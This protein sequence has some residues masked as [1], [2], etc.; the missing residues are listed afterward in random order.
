M[1]FDSAVV[2]QLGFWS[3]VVGTLLSLGVLYRASGRDPLG[4]VRARLLL[5]VPWGTV[6][7]IAG[8]YVVFYVLQGAAQGR[9][10]VVGFRSWSYTYPLGMILAPFAHGSLGHLTGNV[11]STVVYAPVAEYA[12]SHYPTERGTHTFGSWEHNPFVRIGLFVAGSVVV[13]LATSLFIPGALVGFSGVVFAFAGFALVTR[14]LL[15]VFAL[16][17]RRVVN[18][19]YV[20][21]QDPVLTARAEPQF[22]TPFWANIAIQGHALG[23]LVGVLAGL[24]VGRRRDEWASPARVWFAVLVFAVAQ[25][26]YAF[27]WQ[28]STAEFVLF[29]GVGTALV[30]VLAAVVAA[31]VI[32]RDRVIVPRIDLSRREA[33]AGLLLAVVLAIS[34]AAIPFNLVTIAGAGADP[35]AVDDGIEIR[36]YTVTYAE[37]VPNQYVASVDI[38]VIGQP[39]SINESGVVVASSGRSAWEVVVPASRLAFAGRTTVPVGGPGWRETVVANRTTWNVVGGSS[40]YKVYLHRTGEQRRLAFAAE[41]ATVPAV[42]DDTRI[43]IAPT[44]P[45]YELEL[46]R[47]DS[48]VGT[49]PVPTEGQNVTVADIT[50]NRTGKSLRAIHD[51]TRL[52]IATFRLK[53]KPDREDE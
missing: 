6:A 33:A 31:A 19:F 34:V 23:L 20:S 44:R 40:T 30:F 15:A 11:I 24:W 50:F 52:R 47:N 46:R 3:L 28:V 35:G 9:P 25:A 27:Y 45:G 7:V 37:G 4:R 22:V 2:D 26:L 5:G 53:G 13:G 12:W 17:A 10:V 21:V 8:L 14:P 38:P 43:R 49:D 42:V 39:L 16:V 36:D 32:R 18:L 29:R 1:A 48:V 51:G 41:P